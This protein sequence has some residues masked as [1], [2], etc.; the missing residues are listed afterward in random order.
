MLEVFVCFWA[1]VAVA[2]LVAAVTGSCV[3][4]HK[5]PEFISPKCIGWECQR[6][7]SVVW[8]KP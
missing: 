2:A 3:W 6:C 8:R 7:H 1:A 5:K 4:G